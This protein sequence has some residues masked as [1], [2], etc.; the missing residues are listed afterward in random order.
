MFEQWGEL[1]DNR[2]LQ[3]TTC[4]LFSHVLIMSACFLFQCFR[5]LIIPKLL[6]YDGHATNGSHVDASAQ[7]NFMEPFTVQ[8]V[9]IRLEFTGSIQKR[10]IFLFG[11][12]VYLVN[13]DPTFYPPFL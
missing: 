5:W 4:E 3:F 10:I 1:T 12:Y 11:R 9:F 2:C 13:D 6:V 8:I 7:D